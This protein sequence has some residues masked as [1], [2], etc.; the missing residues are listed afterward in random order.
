MVGLV[1]DAHCCLSWVGP[2]GVTSVK[3]R[4][5]I[6]VP[7]RGAGGVEGRSESGSCGA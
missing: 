2:R 1:G 3:I 6:G 4:V 5:A 7:A